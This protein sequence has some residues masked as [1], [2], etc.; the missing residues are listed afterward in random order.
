MPQLK[1]KPLSVNEAWQGKRFKTKAYKAYERDILI[2]L[3]KITNIEN[4]PISLSLMFGLSSKNADIDNPVKCFVDCL[5]KKYG[6]NDRQIYRLTVQ[7]FDVS[8]GDE[9]IYF[10]IKYL[11]S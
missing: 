11:D 1:I 10:D 9:Y 6:F 2:M 3:P 5:Q 8:K 7:K 4:R